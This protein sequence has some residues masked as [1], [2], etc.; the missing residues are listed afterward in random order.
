VVDTILQGSLVMRICF[1]TA[2]EPQLLAEVIS[3]LPA[4][5]ALAASNA[6][7]ECNSVTNA[8]ACDLRANCYNLARR[9]VAE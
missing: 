4:D 9:L 5:A 1:G 8:E 2:P 7:F 3:P 6:N